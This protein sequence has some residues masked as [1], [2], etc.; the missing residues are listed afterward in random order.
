[1]FEVALKRISTVVSMPGPGSAGNW[2]AASRGLTNQDENT[3]VIFKCKNDKV[4]EEN[5]YIIEIEKTQ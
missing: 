3:M 2:D 5:N 1:M 4:H